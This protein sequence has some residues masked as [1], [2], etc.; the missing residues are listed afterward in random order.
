L[1]AE[2]GPNIHCIAEIGK[3]LFETAT[4]AEDHWP[5][6]QSGTKPWNGV[7][8]IFVL[9]RKASNFGFYRKEACQASRIAGGIVCN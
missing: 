5:G 6:M 3:L 1:L 7:E 9:I 4:L 8:L 2:P